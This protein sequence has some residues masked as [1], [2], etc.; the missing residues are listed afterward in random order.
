MKPLQTDDLIQI[1]ESIYGTTGFF[2][3]YQSHKND[4]LHVRPTA[5]VHPDQLTLETEWPT[6]E[7]VPLLY[8]LKDGTAY[9]FIAVA[10]QGQYR[11]GPVLLQSALFRA[12]IQDESYHQFYKSLPRT[13][14]NRLID[15]AHL[16]YRLLNGR[17][18]PSRAI[19]TESEIVEEEIPL[20][21]DVPAHTGTTA[22]RKAWQREQQIIDWISSGQ[23]ERLATT[24]SLP[25]YGEFGSL[26]RHQPLRAEKNLLLGT[27]LLSAR[28][29]IIGGLEPDE[30]FS[31]SDRMIDSIEAAN[32]ISELRNRHVR[33]TVSFAEAVKQ[34]QEL[35]HSPHVLAAI[36]YIQQHL[37]DP[38]SVSSISHAIHVSSNYLSVLFKDETGLP[39]ARYVIRE[40]I[41]EAKR[42]LRSSDDSLL[43]ISNKL[44]FSSQSHFS[45]AF[46]Q[47]TGET[48][49]HYRQRHYL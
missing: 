49:T 33:I 10:D 26:A 12:H 19:R 1:A 8:T 16:V 17:Q 34:I 40:R 47:T 9:L 39:L 31:L 21:A 43:T 5:P 4:S 2:V 11:I 25:A 29:A 42:L 30:A 41:R 6:A 28:A 22:Y 13:T 27:V 24:Y 46:K 7:A 37:Y 20:V 44:H 32:S 15:C 23:S 45:Q 48:P 3:S 38:L 36:R 18:L 14:E 35:R